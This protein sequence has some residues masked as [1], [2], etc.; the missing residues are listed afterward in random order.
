MVKYKQHM[1]KHLLL[2]MTLSCH[3][4]LCTPALPWGKVAS[5]KKVLSS[6]L[7]GSEEVLGQEE[8]MTDFICTISSFC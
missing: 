2:R 8:W 5:S 3:L 1:I 6:H 7:G 4:F